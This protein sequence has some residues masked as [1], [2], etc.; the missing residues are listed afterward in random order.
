MPCYRRARVM[1]LA[2]YIALVDAA[3]RAA[4]PPAV[5]PTVGPNDGFPLLSRPDEHGQP[6]ILPS[7]S[8]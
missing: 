7:A 2:A 5:A 8:R 6:F 4:D 1:R 3:L